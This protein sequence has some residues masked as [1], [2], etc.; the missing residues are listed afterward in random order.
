MAFNDLI[1]N[2]YAQADVSLDGVAM[3]NSA[4]GPTFQMLRAK[5]G[6]LSATVGLNADTAT[7]TLTPRWEVSA[8][9]TSWTLATVAN[10]AAYVVQADQAGVATAV[11]AMAA[12]DS[13]YSQRFARVS[14]LLGNAGGGAADGAVVG[15][16]FID[17]NTV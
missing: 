2:N 14:V 13:V 10:N 12:P 16:N 17:S 1:V 11:H 15:H 6:T 5:T 9:G 7:I 3:D 8:D 4:P